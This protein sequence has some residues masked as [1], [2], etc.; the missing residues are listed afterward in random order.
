MPFTGFDPNDDMSLGV[1]NP[2]RQL[3]Q[4]D[5]LPEAERQRLRRELGRLNR[6]RILMDLAGARM[7]RSAFAERQLEEVMTAFWFD[8][9]NVH[10]PK[11][12]TRWLVNDYERTAIRPHVFGSF[13]DML[14][15]TARHP[16]SKRSR[17]S[18]RASPGEARP[19]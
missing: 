9:F 15:A 18:F 16:A 5:S 3:A 2:L 19:P 14:V 7:Y 4:S 11:G 17:A 1:L 8:H 10:F 13:E 6:G 12:A